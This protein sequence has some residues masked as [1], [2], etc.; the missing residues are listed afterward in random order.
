MIIIGKSYTAWKMHMTNGLVLYFLTLTVN[1]FQIAVNQCW[2]N[3]SI[4]LNKYLYSI[5][6]I[7]LANRSHITSSDL[8]YFLYHDVLIYVPMGKIEDFEMLGDL[9]SNIWNINTYVYI[10]KHPKMYEFGDCIWNLVHNALFRV[11]YPTK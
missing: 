4:N 5:I 3:V 10:W 8:Q 9:S 6:H 11:W 1:A 2:G 7:L